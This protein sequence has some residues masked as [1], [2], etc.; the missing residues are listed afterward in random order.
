ME[1]SILSSTISTDPGSHT[2]GDPQSL[3]SSLDLFKYVGVEFNF[4][5]H[6]AR[7]SANRCRCL[8]LAT[9]LTFCPVLGT[10]WIK[11]FAR[12]TLKVR[13]TARSEF[14]ARVAK[15]IFVFLGPNEQGVSSE[16]E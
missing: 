10:R 8:L 13:Y 14:V 11:S 16:L 12:V 2:L 7:P 4:R 6:L 5:F 3:K 9:T 1:R 15:W